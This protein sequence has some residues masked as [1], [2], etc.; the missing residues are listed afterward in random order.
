[1]GIF[2]RRVPNDYIPVHPDNVAKNDWIIVLEAGTIVGSSP[3]KLRVAR[4][5]LERKIVKKYNG[6]LR[7][8]YYLVVDGFDPRIHALYFCPQLYRAESDGNLVAL[9]GEEIGKLLA[10]LV[11]GAVVK[12]LPWYEPA[13]KSPIEPIIS[14]IALADLDSLVVE[15][16][17][18][19]EPLQLEFARGQATEEG[20]GEAATPEDE[21]QPAAAEADERHSLTTASATARPEETSDASNGASPAA[22]RPSNRAR[23]SSQ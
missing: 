16:P 7:P 17:L 10:R 1:M 18:P 4:A 23:K 11:E 2:R 22:D 6:L 20:A 14:A 15:A 8:K 21:R 3:N 5:T 19:G 13:E 12:K 9:Q